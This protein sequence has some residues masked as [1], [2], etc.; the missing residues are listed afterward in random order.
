MCFPG[1]IVGDEAGELVENPSWLLSRE[2][3][4]E[5]QEQG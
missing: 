1:I 2:Q 4:R 3:T 5:E